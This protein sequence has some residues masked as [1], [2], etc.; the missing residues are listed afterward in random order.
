MLVIVDM[1]FEA[2]TILLG[3]IL[4]SF[5]ESPG[6][7][8]DCGRAVRVGKSMERMMFLMQVVR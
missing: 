8:C 6:A 3:D 1:V 5:P 4:G 7:G 2:C